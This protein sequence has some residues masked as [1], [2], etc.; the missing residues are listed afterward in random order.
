MKYDLKQ[1]RETPLGQQ[2]GVH[3]TQR[4]ELR[5]SIPLLSFSFSKLARRFEADTGRHDDHLQHV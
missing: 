5:R 3:F 2:L 4:A 1:Y